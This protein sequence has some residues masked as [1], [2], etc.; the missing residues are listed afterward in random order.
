MH[1]P[2]HN[3]SDQVVMSRLFCVTRTLANDSLRMLALSIL[4]KS[5]SWISLDEVKVDFV[6]K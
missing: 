4:A 5:N 2:E 6:A 1:T 3:L